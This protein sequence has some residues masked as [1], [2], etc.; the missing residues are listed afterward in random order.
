[1]II[2][3]SN[4]IPQP[5]NDN[6]VISDSKGSFYEEE[7]EYL[8]EYIN[9]SFSSDSKS[10]IEANLDPNETYYI[11]IKLISNVNMTTNCV[12]SLYSSNE[13]SFIA[14]SLLDLYSAIKVA[15]LPFSSL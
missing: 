14:I 12:V 2:K 9:S 6:S 1:M 8:F 10:S 5:K 15:I 11:M 4:I 3:K 13:S 7:N